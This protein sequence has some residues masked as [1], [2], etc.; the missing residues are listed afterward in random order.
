MHCARMQAIMITGLIAHV[1]GHQKNGKIASGKKS[2]PLTNCNQAIMCSAID[3]AMFNKTEVSISKIKLNGCSHS[4]IRKRRI[5]AFQYGYLIIHRIGNFR[6]C[7][8]QCCSASMI[9]EFLFCNYC[10]QK[11]QS[12]FLVKNMPA[13]ALQLQIL[14]FLYHFFR[15]KA[16]QVTCQI[17]FQSCYNC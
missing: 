7:L 2:F 6:S 10:N 15:C 1:S 12:S 9:A 16:K 3:I 11:M 14:N 4:G 17:I 8:E 13:N 5:L